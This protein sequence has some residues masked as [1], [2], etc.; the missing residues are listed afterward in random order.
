MHTRLSNM[1]SQCHMML[2]TS[3][4]AHPDTSLESFEWIPA[5]TVKWSLFGVPASELYHTSTLISYKW[6]WLFRLLS[7]RSLSLV[8]SR[9]VPWI[10]KCEIICLIEQVN[11]SRH[12]PIWSWS[13]SLKS[14]IIVHYSSGETFQ[15]CSM[16]VGYFWAPI[17]AK[18]KDAYSNMKS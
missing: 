4:A 9:I 10:L 18:R 14:C 17:E 3:P 12:D 2:P 13:S 1:R 7:S 11:S 5:K 15:P 6:Q 8:W 16:T